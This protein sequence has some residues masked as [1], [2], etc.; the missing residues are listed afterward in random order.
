HSVVDAARIAL[1]DHLEDVALS[2]CDRQLT[3]MGFNEI[4]RGLRCGP[5]LC[6][7]LLQATVWFVGRNDQ[8]LFHGVRRNNLLKAALFLIECGDF[9]DDKAH[10]LKAD[11][12]RI[13]NRRSTIGK[14]YRDPSSRLQNA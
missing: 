5:A 4:P 6:K 7:A 13:P 14:D 10:L 12:N 1:H 2:L 11:L 9:S 8:I 3:E